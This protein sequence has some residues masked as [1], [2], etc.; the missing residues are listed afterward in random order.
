MACLQ[1]Q[2]DPHADGCEIE[3]DLLLCVEA[4]NG[5]TA[6][7]YASDATN[8]AVRFGE[9]AALT[10]LIGGNLRNAVKRATPALYH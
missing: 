1:H 10:S 8:E 5:L 7:L 2:T 4:L 6:L 3:N 9:I